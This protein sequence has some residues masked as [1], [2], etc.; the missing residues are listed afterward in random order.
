MA[1][2]ISRYLADIS[3][4]SGVLD[5]TLSTAAQT[6][7]TS[8]GTLSSLTVS[9]SA[10]M[11]LTTAA[12]PNITSVGTLSSLSTSGNI[13]I[14]GSNNELRLYEGANY[15]GF[16]APAL[17]ADK[18]WVL[19]AADGSNGQALVT[20][21]SGGLSFS[22]ISAG[23]N[24]FGT[25]AVSGQSNVAADSN[26]DTLTLVAGSNIT[27]TTTPGTDTVT[28]AAGGGKTTEEIQD[29]VGAM[30]TSNTETRGSLTY[31]DGDGTIDLVVDDMTA[32]T[33]TVTTINSNT[34]NYLITGTGTANTLQ[35]ESTLTYDG[36]TL[37][38]NGNQINTTNSNEWLA[39]NGG[40]SSPYLRMK[41][42]GTNNG[43][44]QF[45]TTSSYFWNDRING[46]IKLAALA[47][48]EYYDGAYR[49]MWHSGNAPISATGGANQ[50]LKS[51]N[52]GYLQLDNWIRTGSGSGLYTTA[53]AYVYPDTTYGWF[54]RHG[55]GTTSSSVR[56]QGSGGAATFWVYGETDYDQGF[57]TSTGSW[58]WKGDNSGNW[59]ATANV[60][61]YSDIRLKE[62]VVTI[63]NA[64]EKVTKLRG[65]EYTRIST[66][67]REIGVIAQEVKEV[68]PELVSTID[69]TSAASGEGLEDLHVMKYQNTVGLL[70]EAIKELKAEVDEL[71]GN[72]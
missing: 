36:A 9:G 58:S 2:S 72:K 31:Q 33:N 11:T 69:E 46:G 23:G 15:V 30:F 64:L 20:D 1:K 68:V 22:S 60:T 44:I 43:Y 16:E 41:T 39:Y 47:A 63:P 53:G 10:A 29:I 71:K 13:S 57:L 51:T 6:N 55:G 7:I 62:E 19:P 3:S 66:Q 24:A 42:S 21:G 37:T 32:D 67:E 14:T 4:T 18:I 27:I 52:S 8:L 59:T 12:Q 17:S 5:G 28:V 61:A 40:G 25:I 26:S 65:V 35:G 48:P 38:V 49:T 50:V 45:T 70:I 54:L 56:G 34:N